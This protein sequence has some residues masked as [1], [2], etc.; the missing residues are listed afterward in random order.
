MSA[1]IDYQ[2]NILSQT[3]EE[4]LKLRA[5]GIVLEVLPFTDWRNVVCVEMNYLCKC[6]ESNPKR[7][8]VKTVR[9]ECV[10]YTCIGETHE[11]MSQSR[12]C[13]GAQS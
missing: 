12:G 2:L 7:I 5:I 9:D 13:G 1:E 4:T 8:S 6:F 10:Y 3:L 11:V